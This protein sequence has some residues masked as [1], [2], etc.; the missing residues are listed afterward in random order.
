MDPVHSFGLEPTVK[1][2]TGWPPPCGSARN[3]ARNRSVLMRRMLGILVVV[4]SLLLAMPPAASAQSIF[5]TLSGTVRD[6]S[7]AVVPGANVVI[8]NVNSQLV[9]KSISNREGF[10]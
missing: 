3:E 9:Y 6:A 2:F 4:L 7:G 1:T 5:A 10:F 8:K